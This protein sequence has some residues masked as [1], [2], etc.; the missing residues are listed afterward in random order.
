MYYVSICDKRSI[1]TNIQPQKNITTPWKNGRKKRFLWCRRY[2][3]QV[4]AIV[5]SRALWKYSAK[6]KCHRQFSKFQVFVDFS[7]LLL[8]RWFRRK[9][10]EFRS[11]RRITRMDWTMAQLD[12]KLTEKEEWMHF[13]HN[14]CMSLP[15]KIFQASPKADPLQN[16]LST[17]KT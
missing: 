2:C 11:G 15:N 16:G 3:W 10:D 4:R 1:K 17:K 12:T 13:S 8:L 5:K 6:R 7:L 9:S 14:L